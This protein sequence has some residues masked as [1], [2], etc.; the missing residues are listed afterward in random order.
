VWTDTGAASK[1][2]QIRIKPFSPAYFK[3][4]EEIPELR[5][6]VAIGDQITVAGKSIVIAITSSGVETLSDSDLRRIVSQW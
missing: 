3:L 4:I 2:N 6:I 5:E 1:A